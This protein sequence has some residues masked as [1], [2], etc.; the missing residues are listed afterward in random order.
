MTVELYAVVQTSQL[1]PLFR[2]GKFEK[3]FINPLR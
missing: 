3:N 1:V 2:L